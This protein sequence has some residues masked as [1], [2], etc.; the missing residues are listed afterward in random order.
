MGLSFSSL[1]HRI[2]GKHQVRILMVGLD[3]AGK[4]TILYKLKLGEVIQTIPTI[5]FNVDSVDYKN[6][7]FT[8]WDIGGQESIRGLWHH[9]FHNSR[10]VIFVVDSTDRGR[11]QEAKNELMELTKATELRDSAFLIYANKQCT[12]PVVEQLFQDQKN[13]MSPGEVA[14]Q[15]E[16]NKLSNR[17]WF[18]Q[19]CA[20][21]NEQGLYEGLKWLSC[22]IQKD[23]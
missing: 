8:V 5:G 15:L 23:L 16:L 4:T 2:F 21:I 17:N 3:N 18:I 1:F 7:S 9:Y 22:A 13:A 11:M 14:D 12:Q 6:I 20:A 19:A 10:G